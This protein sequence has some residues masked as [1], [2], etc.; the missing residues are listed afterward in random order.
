MIL[1]LPA[2]GLASAFRLHVGAEVHVGGVEP[3]EE[4]HARLH[5]FANEGDG[6]LRH[7]IVDCLHALLGQR[8]GVFD[9]LPTLAVGFAVQHPARTEPLAE[10]REFLGVRIVWV[11]R[12]LLGVEMVE[13]AE[14]LVE[15]MHR[16]QLL[17]AI[18]EVIFAEL[19]GGVALRL[20]HRGDSWNRVLHALLGARHADLGETGAKP[21]LTGD[22]AGATCC[23]A[24]LCVVVG[25][26][27]AFVGDAVDVGRGVAHHALGEA[28][29]V[30]LTD[31]V[32][33]H[34]QDVR[35]LRHDSAPRR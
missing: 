30:R 3:N 25:E 23:A 8:P 4:G 5:L 10:I 13:V 15:T 1:A 26:H 32:A 27:H 16:R 21:A 7:L 28:A 24:L 2:S 22:E 18:A 17:V 20:E 12:L 33:P 34:N 19:A 9:R 29:Q 6:P 11:F 31:I 35:F 14:E